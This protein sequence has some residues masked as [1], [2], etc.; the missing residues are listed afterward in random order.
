MA[1]YSGRTGNFTI[2]GTP[3]LDI[4]NY[5]NL[6]EP[7][8]L[9]PRGVVLKGRAGQDT[10]NRIEVI[11]GSRFRANTIDVSSIAA[12]TSTAISV[13][14]QQQ[15][16]TI[17]NI[18]GVGSLFRNVQNF[19]RVKGTQN[20]DS[21]LGSNFN[22]ILRGN[23]GNDF[24]Q[25]FRGEDTLI[26]GVGNDQIFGGAGSDTLTG[27]DGDDILVGGTGKDI[28]I[29]GSGKDI[30]RF[31]SVRDSG[32]G[33]RRDIIDDLSS[34]FDKISIANIDADLNIPGNQ[35]F[36]FIGTRSFSGTGGEVRY[37]TSGGS[38]ILQIDRQG[39][40]NVKAEMEI[41]LRGVSS[42]RETDFI[43]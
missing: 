7:I 25:G 20:S 5:S 36:R 28:L 27:N 24:I 30:F 21:I 39:D 8:T 4:I 16:L 19:T 2:N 18:P 23:G 9:L 17:N 26:G 42:V 13:N 12:T 15:S 43:L 32:T 41:E 29:D 3:G 37:F 22:N 34:G 40:G 10:L 38:T 1:I 33:R 31:D 11:I 6:K 35:A 14:L